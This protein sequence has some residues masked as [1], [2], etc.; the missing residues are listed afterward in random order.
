VE[1]K[2]AR[3]ALAAVLA[4]LAALTLD[5]QLGIE[6]LRYHATASNPDGR[7]YLNI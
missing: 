2:T 3:L 1:S 4:I 5:G 7:K 6:R